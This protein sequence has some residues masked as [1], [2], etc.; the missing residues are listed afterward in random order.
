MDIT[1]IACVIVKMATV[2]LTAFFFTLTATIT[3]TSIENAVAV[4]EHNIIINLLAKLQ[5][6][7]MIMLMLTPCL[8]FTVYFILR[9][10]VKPQL[11]EFYVYFIVFSTTADFLGDLGSVTALLIKAGLM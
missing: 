1:V 4:M 5:G 9:N 2:F 10:R 7:T 8:M 3:Q 11:L 6:T